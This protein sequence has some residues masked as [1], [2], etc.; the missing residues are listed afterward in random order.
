MLNFPLRFSDE[1]GGHRDMFVSSD[2]C[3]SSTEKGEHFHLSFCKNERKTRVIQKIT[4]IQTSSGCCALIN[5]FMKRLFS[6]RI[7][8]PSL[9]M[10]PHLNILSSERVLTESYQLG[11]CDCHCTSWKRLISKNNL[12]P[13]PTLKIT[14]SWEEN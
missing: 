3:N 14:N 11:W 5:C 10:H 13:T 4:F 9:K 7:A 12:S 8:S 6:Q 1:D 2:L